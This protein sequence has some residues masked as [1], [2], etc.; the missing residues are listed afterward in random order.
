MTLTGSGENIGQQVW[1]VECSVLNAG[2]C[3]KFPQNLR[4]LLKTEMLKSKKKEDSKASK[5]QTYGWFTSAHS[6]QI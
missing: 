4:F 1:L 2:S 6:F 5:H 3:L